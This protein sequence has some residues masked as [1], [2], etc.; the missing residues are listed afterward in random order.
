MSIDATQAQSAAVPGD[1]AP[2]GTPA[3]VAD[4]AAPAAAEAPAAA[5]SSESGG[6][7]PISADKDKGSILV[8]HGAMKKLKEAERAAGA[9]AFKADLDERAK[10]LGFRD[11]DALL[12]ARAT[13]KKK[14]KQQKAA[15]AA[16]VEEA[17]DDLDDD[18]EEEVE[19]PP[20]APVKV[21]AKPAAPTSE[22]MNEELRKE[23]KQRQVSERKLREME[24]RLEAQQAQAHVE[25]A[26]IL[27]G[28]KDLD[29]LYS[30]FQRETAGFTA[31]QAE[32][33]DLGPWIAKKRAEQ[34]HLFGDAIVPIDTSRGAAPA[35]G[36]PAKPAAEK[37]APIEQPREEAVTGPGAAV[38]VDPKTGQY[39][40]SKNEKDALLQKIIR[41]AAGYKAPV[42][43]Q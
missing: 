11:M 21:V 25:R 1:A 40:M 13:E 16:P 9:A 37:P 36:A 20:P 5:N 29:Y 7:V 42:M 14:K 17:D 31:E 22:A 41:D 6:I 3:P 8:P 32:A 10:N 34:S 4:A 12:E 35:P 18:E 15:A 2:G 33:F 28:A 38:A 19:A 43:S 30:R 24:A 27:A 26:L 39:T 23:R